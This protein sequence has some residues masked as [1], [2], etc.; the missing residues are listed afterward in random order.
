ME[1][2]T[3]FISIGSNQGDREKAL[4]DAAASLNPEVSP[5][6]FSKIYETPPW[7]YDQQPPFLNQ[8][9]RAETALPPLEL[10][11][12]FKSI[13][14]NIGR[15]PTFRYGPRVIDVDILFYDA[16]VISSE[17]LTIPHPEIEKR[18][19]VLV[20]MMDIAPDFIHPVNGRSITN[21][22]KDLPTEN[23]KEYQSEEEIRPN[24]A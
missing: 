1:S 17:R 9:I 10:L 3:V 11:D 23:I 2:H 22:L 6:A 13:E 21:L 24:D 5:T 4:K 20:P 18:A 7:G 14:I 12:K 8:V 16:T 15:Q 19:F